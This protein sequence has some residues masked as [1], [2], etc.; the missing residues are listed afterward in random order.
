MRPIGKDTILQ[1][2]KSLLLLREPLHGLGRSADWLEAWVNND[3][4]PYPLL[5]VDAFFAIDYH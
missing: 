1:I 3:L 5:A 4:P 2:E